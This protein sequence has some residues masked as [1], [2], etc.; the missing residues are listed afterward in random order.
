MYKAYNEVHL[1]SADRILKM[2]EKEQD[3]RINENWR[4][5]W[6]R[7]ILGLLYILTS[8]YLAVNGQQLIASS[9]IIVLGLAVLGSFFHNK[10]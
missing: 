8:A 3:N 1:G 7:F 2:A 10:K 5:H 6:L 9:F 4:T